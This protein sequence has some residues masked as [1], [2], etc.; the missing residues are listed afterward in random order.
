MNRRTFLHRSLGGLS[1]LACTS[2]PSLA[3][4][5]TLPT[6]HTNVSHIAA[7]WRGPKPADPYFAGVLQADWR[8]KTLRIGY[9][10]PLPT[11]PHGL[12]PTAEGSL[13]VV[14]VRPGSWLMRFDPDGKIQ[15]QFT[16]AHHEH[17]RLNGHAFIDPQRQIVFTTETDYRTGRGKIGVR[18]PQSLQKIAEWD[19]G[20]IEP[21]QLEQD[22][23]GHLMIANGG[24][25]R[26]LDD[27]KYNLDQMDA[28]LVQLDGQSGELLHRWQLADRRLSLRHLAWSHPTADG[29]RLLGIAMQAEHAEA[30]DRKTAPT[31][32]IFD[33]QNLLTPCNQGDPN[34]YAGDL[35]PALNGGFAVSSNQSGATRLWHPSKPD[36]LQAIVELPECYALTN[37]GPNGYTLIS[38]APGLVRW[39]PREAAVFIPWPQPMALD[40]H[41]SV[42]PPLA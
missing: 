36:R 9:S 40:N 4:A 32:A 16:L 15:T 2:F 27:K 41:W 25:P 19:A 30:A 35:C 3:Q 17:T 12:H 18:D 11:R 31:L 33:G 29:R 1:G 10:A 28:S 8:N 37:T 39:H 20:G 26:T 14:G 6:S 23:N 24:I 38:T 7:A 34:G 42:M 13:L 22:Q 5:A 21:H